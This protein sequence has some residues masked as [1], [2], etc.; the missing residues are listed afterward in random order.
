M[1]VRRSRLSLDDHEAR[2]LALIESEG[3]NFPPFELVIGV[4]RAFVGWLDRSGN[5]FVPTLLLLAGVLGERLRLEGTVSPLLLKNTDKASGLFESWWRIKPVA[6]E[7]EAVCSHRSAGEGAG[8]FFTRGVDSWHSA[9]RDRSLENP[10]RI[11]HLIYAPD[12]DRQYGPGSRRRAFELTQ[13]A[14]GCLGL[15]L[16]RV[17]HNGRELLDRFVNWELAHGGVLAGIGL[18]LG[19]WLADVYRASCIDSSRLIPWGSNPDLDRLWSTEQTTSH[20]DGVDVT[21]T[22]KVIAIA[23][24]DVALSRLKVCWREDIETNCGRCEKCVRTQCALA[25]AGALERAPVFVE[26]LT[27]KLVMDLPVIVPVIPPSGQEVLWSEL[28]ESFTDE[29]GLVELRHAARGRLPA[30]HPLSMPGLKRAASAVTLEVP[31][32]A[33]VTLLPVSAALLLPGPLSVREGFGEPDAGKRAI[34]VTWTTAAPGRRG[35]PLRPTSAMSLEILDACRVSDERPSRWCLIG[36]DAP[37]TANLMARLTESWG[38]GV[39]WLTRKCGNASDGDH[40]IPHEE[41][42]LIQRSSETR[43]W[44]GRG[45]YLDPFLIIESLRH[46]CLPL[47]CVPAREHDALVA[48]LPPGLAQFTLSMPEEGPIPVIS[49]SE[50][51]A[52]IDEGLSVLLAGSMERDMAEICSFFAYMMT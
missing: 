41:A 47:Q 6:V 7:A 38:Q 22:N 21:R 30:T 36:F 18:A 9:L 1:I 17:S 27:P 23:S 35:V 14:A 33:A 2:I 42:S 25:I 37:G 52:R 24:S 12:F 5:A 19:G 44:C 15:P 40:G 29:P 26:K 28:C 16:I 45:D 32:D 8:L 31:S 13:E 10:G 43:V 50:R 20:L 51:A 34:E 48:A 46:G 39:T 49:R 11:T 3:S 4:P